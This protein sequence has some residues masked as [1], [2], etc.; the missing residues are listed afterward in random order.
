[1]RHPAPKHRFSAWDGSQNLPLDAD[2]IL[3]ALADDLM[4]YG[5]LRWA[6]RNLMS[7][8]M[9]V[10]EGGYMQGLRDMLKQL[11]DQ[12]R[13]RLEQ[14][15]LSS[16]FDDFRERLDEIVGMEKERIDD[17]LNRDADDFSGDVLKNIAERNR[18][19]LEDMP[20]D[21][22]SQ[23][24]E[25]E[26]YEFLNPDAQK[27]FLE[28]LNDLRK[29]MANTFFNN[30]ENMVNNL[31]DGDI[32]RMKD[33]MKA[34][35]DMLVKKIAGEDP[36]FEDF[37]KTFGDMFG[38]N[39]PQSLDELLEQMQQQMAAA[40]SLLNSLSPEQ[41]AQLQSLLSD[42]FSDPELNAEM[43]KLAKEMAFLNPDGNQYRFSGDEKLGLDAAMDL[44][45]EMSQLDELIEQVQSA[46][47]GG[48][49]DR[50]DRDL[51]K[52]LMGDDASEDLDKLNELLKALEAAGYIRPTGD[53]RWEL[54][55]RGS[56]MIGQKA[57]GEIYERL[58][59]QSMG[60]HAV[61]EEGRFGERLEQTKPYE[62]GDPFQLHMPRTLRNAIDRNG[63][64]APIQLQQDDF[65]VYRSEMITS[66]A[67]AML[68]DLSWS[69]ALRGSFQAAKKV[70][71]AL[72]NLITS[73]YP[74]DSF[75]IIG[76]AA[77]AKELKAHDLPYLQWDEYVLG[78]N[79]QHALLLAEKLLA[80]HTGG[81]K[82][83]IMISDGEPTA[84]LE[85][86]QAQFAYPATPETIRA[87]FKAVKHCTT[88]GI[89][90]N[91]FMLDSNY[92]LKAFMDEIAKINGGRVFYTSPEKLGEYIL[93]D[94]V[95]H[96][97]K[98]LARRA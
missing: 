32:E 22:A 83:I 98:R 60:N 13:Q 56:R 46:E 54:T 18:E 25:L 7:R 69:M 80:K 34:L 39:P 20:E 88:R 53:D 63:P 81:T 48:D 35:N 77:Y 38:D 94:Y 89:A 42:R 47:R 10:P 75:Y 5:D 59:R 29:S 9:Q 21:V 78:T 61:P 30:I 96:K 79:M 86:G 92:Y 3:E 11:R 55:P 17:W 24:K 4:E 73:Q 76:F 68:V 67:T 57:L 85:N 6:M 16:I 40:Q 71:L 65:E 72:H 62:Y 28:L 52:E 84:H 91:T 93:V 66:T 45:N 44:M 19:I 58:K 43:A 37:M 74:K 23:V 2:Q 95:Q 33:M 36:G 31:S 87:T 14:F 64:G 41:Q 15:D 8:G 97:R 12:K 51:L 26:K 90:I 70:A 49:L 50:I 1:M 27:K 82:Q